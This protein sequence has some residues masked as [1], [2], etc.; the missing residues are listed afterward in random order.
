[1]KTKIYKQSTRRTCKNGQLTDGFDIE[2]EFDNF[3]KQPKMMV[4]TYNPVTNKKQTFSN[5]DFK[6][7]FQESSPNSLETNL[8]LLLKKV[9]R[10]VGENLVQNDVTNKASVINTNKN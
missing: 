10:F 2:G 6:K 5:H 3:G 9:K 4:E 7:L 8:K 1:M